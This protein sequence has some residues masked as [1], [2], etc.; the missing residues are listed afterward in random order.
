MPVKQM[1][2]ILT[3]ALLCLS[4]TAVSQQNNNVE[5]SDKKTI[6]KVMDWV[7]IFTMYS[8]V[9]ISDKV[10]LKEYGEAAD[11]L[12]AFVTNAE[13]SAKL[14]EF[15]QTTF[16]NVYPKGMLL[17]DEWILRKL[18][19]VAD[20]QYSVLNA[21][22]LTTEVWF[23]PN[24][25]AT[26]Y[27]ASILFKTTDDRLRDYIVQVNPTLNGIL[28]GKSYAKPRDAKAD[29]NAA[30]FDGL[31]RLK[32]LVGVTF[33]PK[34]AIRFNDE[35]YLHNQT[36]ET[37]QK[38][39][40]SVDLIAVDKNNLPLTG[41]VTW[42]N[43]LGNTSAARF[44]VGTIGLT[45]VNLKA[46][47]D[48]ISVLVNVKEFNLDLRDLLKRLIIEALSKKK[49]QALD[50]L[51]ALRTDSITNAKA[52]RELLRQIERENFPMENDGATLTPM[53]SSPITLSATDSAT[54]FKAD[55]PRTTNLGELKK[56]KKIRTNIRRNVN[57]EAVAD[58]IVKDQA[59]INTLLEDLLKNSGQLIA[60]LIIGK[61]SKGQEDVARDIIVD[62]INQNLERLTGALPEEEEKPLVV[63][64]VNS[65][66][67]FSSTKFVY[68]NP[69]LPID[70]LANF[71]KVLEDSARKRNTYLFLNY[72]QDVS[73]NAYLQRASQARP[74]GLPQDA[75][76][77]T[78]SLVNIPGSVNYM[79]LGSAGEA[80]VSAEKSQKEMIWR[81]WKEVDEAGAL[82]YDNS[83]MI[84]FLST[85]KT[86]NEK[87][88]KDP[89][90]RAY[91]KGDVVTEQDLKDQ[92]IIDFMST[93]SLYKFRTPKDPIIDAF[94]S[95]IERNKDDPWAKLI[96]EKPTPVPYDD[97]PI[98]LA[99]MMEVEVETKEKFTLSMNGYSLSDKSITL[100][101][102]ESAGDNGVKLTFFNALIAPSGVTN[103]GDEKNIINIRKAFDITV[104]SKNAEA[105]KN[106]IKL[107]GTINIVDKNPN[108]EEI[109]ID[110][111]RKR[112]NKY[113]TI[114][115]LSIRGTN[116]KSAVLELGKGTVKESMTACTDYLAD[117]YECKR[118]LPNE[119]GKDFPFT[120]TNSGTQGQHKYKTI[121]LEGTEVNG[122]GGILIHMGD[123][124]SWTKGCLL[125]MSGNEIEEIIEDDK[126]IYSTLMG[127]G[128]RVDERNAGRAF[129]LSMIE[130][131]E[132]KEKRLG[133]S[134]TKKVVIKDDENE[135]QLTVSTGYFDLRQKVNR[136]YYSNV[137]YTK[138]VEQFELFA[139]KL[140]ERA[141]KDKLQEKLTQYTEKLIPTLTK[142]TYQES[143]VKALYE[144]QWAELYVAHA[145]S[146]TLDAMQK[147]AIA[148]VAEFRANL[149]ANFSQV[150]IEND[151]LEGLF[152]DD[153]VAL[154]FKRVL[155]IPRNTDDKKGFKT[156]VPA[157]YTQKLYD[158]IITSTKSKL[159]EEELTKVAKAV[160]K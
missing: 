79:M 81:Y 19:E 138:A 151:I 96:E 5:K 45:R 80:E 149:K 131:I 73:T 97:N 9:D 63:Q 110:V 47:V 126:K 78:I 20:A 156:F 89:G 57:I 133:K 106:Y 100:Y 125:A 115:E 64:S 121:R 33:A 122:R 76:F 143:E 18:N 152:N 2:K 23:K 129:I 53:F 137:L 40:G 130:F 144:T 21:P 148:K 118:I 117:C 38:T 77:V 139:T 84:K 44:P 105:F 11:L 101:A 113:I 36:I 28:T 6:K 107:R 30:L 116:I 51:A 95:M 50:D 85:L 147:D 43:A 75:K 146:V 83:R 120:I 82:K 22:Y 93:L 48:Q 145:S 24:A 160:A 66:E 56:R 111:V 136:Y 98:L 65:L 35:L 34:I 39:A 52:V 132:E 1:K 42:T 10:D 159:I 13:L 140:Q 72:S 74:T 26:N 41:S 46:G 124:I 150:I 90:I 37:W 109:I 119:K 8:N 61:D 135:Q 62:Y 31:D 158:N 87:A 29:V 55:Q 103:E 3:L 104:H 114:S 7:S 12:K 49:K 123:D 70:N 102:Y 4:L 68:F 14:A 128:D 32:A 86:N 92:K 153:L 127:Y 99:R 69:Q 112:S 27:T 54:Y 59:R 88:E 25:D 16:L 94:M 71:V 134:L 108:S 91:L 155:M 58:L 154:L 67:K 17:G 157:G 60:N 15:R 142:Y 141:I